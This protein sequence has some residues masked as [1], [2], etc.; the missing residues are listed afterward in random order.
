MDEA[1]EQYELGL[2]LLKEAGIEPSGAMLAARR[3]RRID[4][5]PR[6]DPPAPSPA[7]RARPRHS[8]PVRS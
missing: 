1:E 8:R 7:R 2:R 5:P 6:R 4:A 3:G